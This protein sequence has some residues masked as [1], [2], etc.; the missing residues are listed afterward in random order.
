MIRINLLERPKAPKP[1]FD[2]ARHTTA[3]CA[4]I[5]VVFAAG[6]GWRYW[7]LGQEDVR[8]TRETAAAQREAARLK[9]VLQQVQQFEQRKGQLQQRVTLIEE[10]RRDQSGPVHLLDEISRSLPDRL[11]LTELKQEGAEVRLQGHTT[12]LTSLSD[13]VGNL[14]SSGYFVRPVEI[15]DSQVET[16]QT[17]G[18]LVKFTVKAT[19]AMPGAA[20]QGIAAPARPGTVPTNQ[21]RAG[22]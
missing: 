17:S 20:P 9:S 11:W 6:I 1:A 15:I 22:A 10:L 14:E 5:L 18:D 3:L 2:I 16:T 8:L 4:L 19:F 13:F 12:S 7:H 21:R